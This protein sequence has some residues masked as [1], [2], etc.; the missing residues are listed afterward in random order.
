MSHCNFKEDTVLLCIWMLIIGRDSGGCHDRTE[1][2]PESTTETVLQGV[3]CQC[4]AW[5][6]TFLPTVCER[7]TWNGLV[8]ASVLQMRPYH[9]YVN[10]TF[11]LMLL[12]VHG[13]EHLIELHCACRGPKPSSPCLQCCI[14]LR[15]WLLCTRHFHRPGKHL[16]GSPQCHRHDPDQNMPKAGK[17]TCPAAQ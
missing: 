14:I 16:S 5:L 9:F 8:I 3:T 12:N 4:L 2:V 7:Q 6:G 15:A 10:M 13:K 11:S 1:L 17:G